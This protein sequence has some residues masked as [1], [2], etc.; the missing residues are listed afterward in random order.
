MLLVCFVPMSTPFFPFLSML[1]M[2]IFCLQNMI[3]FRNK[4]RWGFQILF[5]KITLYKG[6]LIFSAQFL[7][8][9][10]SKLTSFSKFCYLSNNWFQ[11]VSIKKFK[12]SLEKLQ[13]P[14][15]LVF[16]FYYF[17]C[18]HFIIGPSVSKSKA[19]ASM[20]EKPYVVL[21]FGKSSLPLF[22]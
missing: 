16:N 9:F 17:A 15:S 21:A 18:T 13:F 10:T 5:S 22:G 6:N 14:C 20:K 4:Q 3:V 19:H 1:F 2:C 7:P 11:K 12:K 8:C